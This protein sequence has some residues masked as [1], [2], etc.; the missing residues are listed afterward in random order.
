ME[1]ILDVF[2]KME[3]ETLRLGA[4]VPLVR[5][6]LRKQYRLKS[7]VCVSTLVVS[8][9]SFNL[10]FLIAYSINQD[11]VENQARVVSRSVS[12]QTF[13]M[14]FQLMEKGWTK[15]EMEEYIASLEGAVGGTAY[16]VKLYGKGGSEVGERAAGVLNSGSIMN[17]KDG[18]LLTNIYPV[19]AN[20]GCLKCHLK[21]QKGNIL[22]AISVQQDIGPAID[23][24]KK[25][26][27]FFFLVLSPLPFIM[28]G[29][30]LTF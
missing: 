17:A 24:I 23:D 27:T 1:R 3:K 16:R 26:F 19:K 8:F 11:M 18:S 29:F 13:T 9:L 22:G 20:K 21:E 12:Q 7:F 10:A 2:R 14:L 25:K 5:T 15:K 6:I 28:A 4:R 30:I